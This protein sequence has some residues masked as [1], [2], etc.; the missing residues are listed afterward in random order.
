MFGRRAGAGCQPGAD[1]QADGSGR[2][3]QS[4]HLRGRRAG[5][6][7]R[8]PAPGARL[9]VGPLPPIVRIF[10]VGR[11]DLHPFLGPA[12]VEVRAHRGPVPGWTHDHPAGSRRVFTISGLCR[13]TGPAAARP[14]LGGE[15]RPDHHSDRP[16]PPGARTGT[17]LGHNVPGLGGWDLRHTHPGPGAARLEHV[18]PERPGGDPLPAPPDA[19]T[20]RPAAARRSPH[21]PEPAGRQVPDD[22]RRHRATP[23][24]SEESSAGP[25]CIPRTRGRG[26]RGHRRPAVAQQPLPTTV[27]PRHPLGERLGGR[28]ARDGHHLGQTNSDGR[29]SLAIPPHEP[30]RRAGAGD[31][32]RIARLPHRGEPLFHLLFPA[33]HGPRKHAGALAHPQIRRTPGD[34]KTGGRP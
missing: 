32:A 33:R 28:H 3:E 2:E 1:G 20:L 29:W 14:G 34:R 21:P 16:R 22:A 12:V 8:S 7:V 6:V 11:L 5:T 25:H 4:R 30:R 31:G 24:R 27:P 18:A 10:D 9:H 13:R 17:V 26:Y 23:G 19:Q 15:A